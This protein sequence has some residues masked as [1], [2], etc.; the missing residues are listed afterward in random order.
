MQTLFDIK[1]FVKTQLLGYIRE[2]Y[3]HT[4][5]YNTSSFHPENKFLILS[6]GRS[7]ST[8]L[9]NLFNSNPN[10]QSEGELLRGRNYHPERLL[11][12]V[13]KNCS[14]QA[15]VFKLLTYQ[16][17]EIQ[18]SIVNKRSFLQDLV[19]DGYKIIYLERSNSLLQA[20]SV[21]YA[22]QRNIWHYKNVEQVKNFK[23]TLNP[24]QLKKT[25]QNFEKFKLEE[26]RLLENLPYLYLNYEKDL[27]QSD[28]I[29]I[30]VNLLSE[31]L[32]ITINQ[33]NITL[34]K[35]T[36]PDLSNFISNYKEI[37]NYILSHKQLERFAYP[38][39]S[40]S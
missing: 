25:V 29:P 21:I 27:S 30:T 37:M 22:M 18:T 1:Y 9:I 36:P 3:I 24:N 23:I 11:Q 13:E 2:F 38:L 34:K 39:I 20:L 17:L 5:S 10:I 12:R 8:L 33:P 6:S 14:K 19:K 16:L 15:F 40:I 31:Y 32:G 4:T 26:Q 28:K 7:G 35:V